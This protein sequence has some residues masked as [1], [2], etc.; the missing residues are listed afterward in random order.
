MHGACKLLIIQF[1]D[2]VRIKG[3]VMRVLSST[4]AVTGEY[5][6][7]EAY[8]RKLAEIQHWKKDRRKPIQSFVSEYEEYLNGQIEFEKKRTDENIELMKRNLR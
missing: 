3:K 4:G 5:G 8:E 1:S 7:V 6:F 2:S